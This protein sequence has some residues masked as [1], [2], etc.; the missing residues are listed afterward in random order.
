MALGASRRNV[1]M[2]IVREAGVLLAVG[3][4]IGTGLALV[5]ARSAASLL[6]G[7]RPTDPATLVVAIGTLAVVGIAASLLP[8]RRAASVDPMDAV[9]YE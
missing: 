8:A 1:M 7:L 6:F 5:L 4:V 9:R 3:V 2:M